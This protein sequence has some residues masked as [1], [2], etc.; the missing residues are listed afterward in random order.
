MTLETRNSNNESLWWSLLILGRIHTWPKAL[1]SAKWPVGKNFISCKAFMK[2]YCSRIRVL[3][4]RLR[5]S[6]KV[7]DSA[8]MARH[9]IER[10]DRSMIYFEVLLRSI[11]SIASKMKILVWGKPGR[12]K[13]QGRLAR[14]AKPY[15][16]FTGQP[17]IRIRYTGLGRHFQNRD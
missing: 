15:F 5:K 4:F 8:K 7:P 12:K 2:L 16:P 6:E 3:R 9:K 17:K 1:N 11:D 14:I 13:W 10:D